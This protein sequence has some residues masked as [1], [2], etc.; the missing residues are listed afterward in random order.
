MRLAIATSHPPTVA[1]GV[2]RQVGRLAA[3]MERRGHDVEIFAAAGVKLGRHP[4]HLWG[5]RLIRQSEAIGREI[6]ARGM[7]DAILCNGLFGPLTSRARR[8][9]W[10]H[11]CLRAYAGAVGTRMKPQYR[12][13]TREVLGR[14]ERQMCRDATVV[15]VS[16]Q[17]GRELAAEYRAEGVRVIPNGVDLH[18]FTPAPRD[19]EFLRRLGVPAGRKVLLFVGRWEKAKGTDVLLHL[20]DTLRDDAVLLAAVGGTK[21]AVPPDSGVVS[22]EVGWE[23]L[24]RLY[25]SSDCLVFPSY[26]E[27]FGL[28]PAEAA[29]CGLPLVTRAVGWTP[30]LAAEH[31]ETQPFILP[32]HCRAGAFAAAARA[33]LESP[34]LA[35]EVGAAGRKHVAAHYDGARSL[36]QM[37]GLLEATGG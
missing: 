36:S 33:L 19:P 25:R 34:A 20:A 6:E 21:G 23:D 8:V 7:F 26:Y 30:E 12:W 5:G 13:I 15:A 27:G 24:P 29:A 10:F 4:S 35:A 18:H 14:R 1:G 28:A 17:V 16:E 9:C 3:E 2:E 31:P 37:V 32:H 22:A 11:S